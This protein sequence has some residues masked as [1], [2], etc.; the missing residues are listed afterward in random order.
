M[1]SLGQLRKKFTFVLAGLGVVDLVLVVYLLWP[2]GAGAAKAQEESL[3]QQYRTMTHEVAPLRGVDNKLLR[4]REDIKRFYHDQ[5]PSRYSQISEQIMK[6][7]RDNGVNYLSL[8]YSAEPTELPEIQRVSI[9]TTITADYAKIP[10]FINGLERDQHLFL[11]IDRVAV[12]GQ[13]SGAV[14]MQLKFDA[15]LKSTP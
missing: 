15:Y 13:Q 12:N 6:L 4:S 2:G 7:A 3:Q 8:S 1:T 9:S 5:L 10:R 14:I 11:I